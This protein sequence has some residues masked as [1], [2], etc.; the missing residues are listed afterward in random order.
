MKW[1]CPLC[2]QGSHLV[3]LRSRCMTG[4]FS[5]T[6]VCRQCTGILT[7]PSAKR[8]S[9]PVEKTFPS[10]AYVRVWVI[11]KQGHEVRLMSLRGTSTPKLAQQT[12]FLNSLFLVYNS[13]LRFPVDSVKYHTAVTTFR[14]RDDWLYVTTS[15]TTPGTWNNIY[16]CASCFIYVCRPTAIW[17]FQ[18]LFHAA[19]YFSSVVFPHYIFGTSLTPPPVYRTTARVTMSVAVGGDADDQCECASGALSDAGECS[20]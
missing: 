2:M 14:T 6:H 19:T 10:S 4:R 3:D 15:R 18:H 11:V 5:R 12:S 9:P 8:G 1:S 13:R 7:A 16:V 20:E 17:H